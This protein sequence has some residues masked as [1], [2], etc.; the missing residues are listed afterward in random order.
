MFV[1]YAVFLLPFLVCLST[2]AR[3]DSGNL[4]DL[5]LEWSKGPGPFD[6]IF[7]L[8]ETTLTSTTIAPDADDPDFPFDFTFFGELDPGDGSDAI[9]DIPMTLVKQKRTGGKGGTV[10]WTDDL[11]GMVTHTYPG[12]G[13]YPATATH[14]CG[15]AYIYRSYGYVSVATDG[16]GD[17]GDGNKIASV[18]VKLTIPQACQEGTLFG[19][20]DCLL[21][22]LQT[23]VADAGI[24]R[25]GVVNTLNNQIK[26]TRR[27]KD[28]AV[29]ECAEGDTTRATRAME[30]SLRMIQSFLRTVDRN[31][32]ID[33]G[34]ESD[35]LAQAT[36]ISDLIAGLIT[37][38]VCT[39]S[40]CLLDPPLDSFGCQVGILRDDIV[41]NIIDPKALNFFTK[42]LD[43]IDD[44]QEAAGVA[45]EDGN[46]VRAKGK[47]K[48]AVGAL[49]AISNKARVEE[50][51]GNISEELK[52]L[53]QQDVA[54]ARAT[55]D[56]LIQDGVCP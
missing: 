2:F 39:G 46:S 25:T 27:K 21:N 5:G 47:I 3:A 33:D 11:E 35:L 50:R 43:K 42:K 31:P 56:L 22:L 44:Q 37:A 32:H 45:C 49:K 24:E 10:V 16:I 7:K 23:A 1:K 36:P 14:C 30:S 8:T 6:V 9:T 17:D 13:M 55:S 51:R 20:I 52:T 28:D 29:E 18:I 41:A 19:Q 40:A 54:D 53:L 15:D 12:E 34:T 4:D 48:G 26:N 38:G